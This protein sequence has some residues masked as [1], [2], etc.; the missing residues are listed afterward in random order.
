MSEQR[1]IDYLE[2]VIKKSKIRNK[3]WFNNNIYRG[4]GTE[5]PE[6]AIKVLDLIKFK[7]ESYK[8]KYL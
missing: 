5:G 4:T 3:K 6:S 2:K 8:K 1:L 7:I